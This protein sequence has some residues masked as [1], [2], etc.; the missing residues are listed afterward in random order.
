MKFLHLSSMTKRESEDLVGKICRQA[1]ELALK[2]TNFEIEFKQIKTPKQLRGYWRLVVLATPYL[3]ES[4]GNIDNKDEAS[5]FIKMLSGFH[6]EVET[7][8]KKILLPKSLKTASKKDL[9]KLIEKL[10]L[11]CEFFEIKDYELKD[12]EQRDLEQYFNEIK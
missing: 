3:K 2:C 4:Y 7:K 1:W 10:L 6:K 8:T 9:M 12:Q 5:D 11:I